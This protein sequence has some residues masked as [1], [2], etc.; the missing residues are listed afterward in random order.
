MID[1]DT[2][3]WRAMHS[4]C[5]KNMMR[6]TGSIRMDRR[7]E[8]ISRRGETLQIAL[9]LLGYGV[10]S[11][12]VALAVYRAVYPVGEFLA[13][14]F[15]SVIVFGGVSGQC[16]STLFAKKELHVFGA[17]PISASTHLASKV[18]GSIVFYSL[19]SGGIAGPAFFTMLVNEGIFAGMRWIVSI[20]FCV[21]FLCF[22]AICAHSLSVRVFT[23]SKLR[24][25]WSILG[26]VFSVVVV[27]LVFIALMR[28]FELSEVGG[29]W[30]LEEDPL[31]LLFPPYWF[32]A[33]LLF[34]DGHTSTTI[35]VGALLAT[36]GSIPI[37]LYLF[38]R[39][40]TAF[41]AALNDSTSDF[42]ITHRKPYAIVL[43]RL[44]KFGSL[45]Y[46]RVAIWKLAFSHLK[47]DSIFRSTFF[48]Y[49]ILFFI[50]VVIYIA[51]E[52]RPELF[53]D[54]FLTPDPDPAWLLVWTCC[55][56]FLFVFALFEALRS[57]AHA[58][59]CWLFFVS[60]SKL[61][62][63]GAMAVDWIFF[64]FVLP[65]LLLLFVFFSFLWQ[66][67]INA[68]LHVITLGWLAYVAVNLK[69]ILNPDLPFA[70]DASS[71]GPSARLCLN[72][73]LIVV[74][75]FVIFH[76]LASWMYTN[77]ATY[78]ASGL[79]GVVGCVAFRFLAHVRH[80]RKF[81]HA[82]LVT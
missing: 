6:S 21:V 59:A 37:G 23:G 57:S 19:V 8:P 4:L 40:D 11:V 42:D 22:A 80:D 51:E 63:F 55:L 72:F 13:I 74:G 34:L 33:V 54:P 64:L 45:G 67:P 25:V 53:G 65:A 43:F 27:A 61:T 76:T 69:S 17:L 75:G 79:L 77:Y 20:A 3:Q 38:K 78:I 47:Y 18:T 46:E 66:T 60:P 29:S 30:N 39:I 56:L 28:D 5:I 44:L 32:I 16:S 2:R 49:F 48:H 36:F 1:I 73:L 70:R 50:W 9:S 41:L 35:F 12:F 82:D 52:E 31:F 68:L 62:R 71:S 10:M 81:L 24:Y 7:S 26:T 58:P 14:S 15:L